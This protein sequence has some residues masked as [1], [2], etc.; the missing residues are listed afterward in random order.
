MAMTPEERAKDD[1]FYNDLCESGMMH[2]IL[3]LLQHPFSLKRY[4]YY[5]WRPECAE[6]E[7]RE[8]EERKVKNREYARK[9]REKK[10]AAALLPVLSAKEAEANA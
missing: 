9:R 10:R 7:A 6:R 5:P 1:A 2:D 8:A 4:E 3:E